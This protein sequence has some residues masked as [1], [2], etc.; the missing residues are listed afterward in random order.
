MNAE[1]QNLQASTKALAA[2]LQ[3][4]ATERPQNGTAQLQLQIPPNIQRIYSDHSATV[5]ENVN[6]MRNIVSEDIPTQE[7]VKKLMQEI[8]NN[9]QRLLEKMG[10]KF[11]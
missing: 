2:S 6:Q 11:S 8:N 10:G 9:I 3:K 5:N 1:L 4:S 7:K